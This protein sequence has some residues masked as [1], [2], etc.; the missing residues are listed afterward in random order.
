MDETKEIISEGHFEGNEPVTDSLIVDPSPEE[1]VAHIEKTE[2]VL[3]GKFIDEYNALVKKY[4]RQLM[5]ALQIQ[6]IK[7]E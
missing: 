5:P 4:K 6:R 3:D 7:G 1:M 2:A